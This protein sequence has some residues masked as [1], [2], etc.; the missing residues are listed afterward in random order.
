MHFVEIKNITNPL[1]SKIRAGVCDSFYLKLHGLMFTP[2]IS[3]SEGL[4]FIEKVDSKLNSS[5]H[6]FFMRFDISVIWL[7]QKLEVVDKT[8]AR[9][10][11]PYYAPSRPASYI[12][13]AHVSR[14]DQFQIGDKISLEND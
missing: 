5:I 14:L 9:K 12:L 7:N 6:M 3:P 11:R 4:L 10:W 2:P 13:E 1:I 8:L